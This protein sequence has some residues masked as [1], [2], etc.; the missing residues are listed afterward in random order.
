MSVD[1]GPGTRRLATL[2]LTCAVACGGGTENGVALDDG[3][4]TCAPVQGDGG[5]P[6]FV[7]P[8]QPQSTCTTT[9][10]QALYDDCSIGTAAACDAF[11]GDPANLPCIRCMISNSTDPSWGAVVRFAS[12]ATTQANVAGCIALVDG[13]AGPDGCG[14]AYQAFI[15][16]RQDSCGV[17]PSG[18]TSAGLAAFDLCE[19]QAERT[20]C[21]QYA[22]SGQCAQASVYGG[23]LF[24]SF[25]S[26]FLGVGAFFCA[27][28]NDGG[29]TMDGAGDAP[30]E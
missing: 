13:D 22:Q 11:Y 19:S 28:G 20:T 26:Q 29:D 3:S 7:P 17:C 16:C 1:W 27:R 21:M 24:A 9:Q 30:A 23:C 25:E 2:A 8:N 10:I 6:P 12:T 14:A 5:V 4:L 18:S 15:E